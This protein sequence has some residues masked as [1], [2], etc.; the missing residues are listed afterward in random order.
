MDEDAADA[1][2]VP[3]MQHPLGGVANR[4]RPSPCRF[5]D[6]STASRP[7]IAT[8]MGSGLLRRNRPVTADVD[9]PPDARA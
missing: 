8:G 9:T 5:T 2:R 6:R 1:D 7:G 4:A 3:G